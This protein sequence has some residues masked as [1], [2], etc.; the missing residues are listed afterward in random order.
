MLTNAL[1]L[2]RIKRI[3]DASSLPRPLRARAYRLLGV[4]AWELHQLI[5]RGV[6][7]AT[8]MDTQNGH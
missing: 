6:I 7:T 8:R 4:T 3:A 1:T 5:S 2:D